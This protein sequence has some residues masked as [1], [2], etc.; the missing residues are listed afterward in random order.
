MVGT[1]PPT[2]FN[3]VREGSPGDLRAWTTQLIL[4]NS[5]PSFCLAALVWLQVTEVQVTMQAHMH[6]RKWNSLGQLI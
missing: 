4:G 1:Q 3:Y 6:L 5:F 2:H